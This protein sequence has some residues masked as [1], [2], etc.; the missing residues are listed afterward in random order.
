VET[1][2]VNVVACRFYQRQGFSLERVAAAAYPSLPDEV[3][4]LWIKALTP[5]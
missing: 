3:Q 4:L 1:Q 2:Q 5:A